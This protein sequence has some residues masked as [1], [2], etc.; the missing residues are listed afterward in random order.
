MGQCGDRST[1][2]TL[3]QELTRKYREQMGL[4]HDANPPSED[5]GVFRI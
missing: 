3:S 1:L 2:A 4:H 5:Q